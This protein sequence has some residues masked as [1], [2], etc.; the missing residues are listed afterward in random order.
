MKTCNCIDY[1]VSWDFYRSHCIEVHNFDPGDNEYPE[2]RVYIQPSQTSPIEMTN[3]N[4]SDYEQLNS[5][6]IYLQRKLEKIELVKSKK[7][8]YD[9]SDIY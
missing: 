4:K 2:K 8:N 7:D 1:P 3:I 6:V 9:V 5:R